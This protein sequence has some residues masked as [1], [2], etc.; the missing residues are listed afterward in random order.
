[1]AKLTKGRMAPDFTLPDQEG[2]E[3]SLKDFQGSWVLLYFYPKDDTTGCTKEACA[4]RD[5]FPKFKK[6]KAVVLGMSADTTAS[7]KKFAEKYHLPF[8]LLSDTLKKVLKKYNVYGKKKFM[9]REYR[10][11]LRTSF[12][13]DPKG[14]I[15]KI[16]EKVKP[17]LHAG[18]VLADLKAFRK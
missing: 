10:G 2:K 5:E 4:I 3:R 9:G 17:A 7:H 6:M 14:K 16:Y 12:L 11:I 15:V 18:E 13:I 8:I 1:M